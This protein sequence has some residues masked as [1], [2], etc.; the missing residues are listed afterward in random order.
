MTGSVEL[1]AA[2]AA[3]PVEIQELTQAEP[4]P[5]SKP[6]VSYSKGG[7]CASAAHSRRHAHARR[8]VQR[9]EVPAYELSRSVHDLR[10]LPAQLWERY[11]ERLDIWNL[12]SFRNQDRRARAWN[13]AV[14]V[15]PCLDWLQ[16]YDVKTQ[17]YRDIAAG[18]CVF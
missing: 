17:L 7:A 1:A 10:L 13:V 14:R 15:L 3:E 18:E 2:A 5:T 11:G 6:R 12:A 9:T 8:A 16:R 4:E